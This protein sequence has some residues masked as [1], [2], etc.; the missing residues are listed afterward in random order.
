MNDSDP[1]S[2]EHEAARRTRVS[3][4]AEP[5]LC[6]GMLADVYKWHLADVENERRGVRSE[7]V[8]L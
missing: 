3:V 7:G 4:D 2:A 8:V 1:E 6:L 5:D